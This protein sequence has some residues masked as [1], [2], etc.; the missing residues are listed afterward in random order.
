MAIVIPALTWTGLVG[1][2]HQLRSVPPVVPG[3]DLTNVFVDRRPVAWPITVAGERIEWHTTVQDLRSN[4]TL[5][6]YLHLADWNLVP[7]RFMREGLD[8]MLARYRPILMSPRAWDR[9]TAED[10][11]RVPQPMRTLAFRQMAAYW[12][13]Y[14]DLGETYGF[15]PGLIADTLGAIIMTESWF[16]HRGLFVNAE[17]NRDIGLGGASDYARERLR[18]MYEHGLVDAAFADDA[19]VNPWNAT[20]FVALWMSLML[21]EADGDLELAIR[22]YHRGIASAD[23]AAGLRYLAT[24]RSRLSRYIRNRNAPPA[25]DYVWKKG[26]TLERD[27]WP[28]V[29][30]RSRSESRPNGSSA[31]PTGRD[32]EPAASRRDKTR[33][34]AQPRTRHQSAIRSGERARRIASFLLPGSVKAPA[35]RDG[36]REVR[37]APVFAVGVGRHDISPSRRDVAHP[38]GSQQAL[39]GWHGQFTSECTVPTR[40]PAPRTA[41][42]VVGDMHT[43]TVLIVAHD[44]GYTRACGPA[45]AAARLCAVVVPTFERAL[46]ALRHFRPD[47]LVIEEGAARSRHDIPPI[48]PPPVNQLRVFRYPT[49][50]APSVLVA[51]VAGTSSRV[52][53]E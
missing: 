36:L 49:L 5:W 13:G 39:T 9:M 42:A 41:L 52:G 3:P 7:G 43:L 33:L 40:R 26:R 10:W 48:L 4:L 19:Y 15:P 50:P 1:V 29:A 17:G 18:Q 31:A 45:F 24:V 20:R 34:A 47:V 27:E 11:D 25:W 53:M 8:N 22:A 38:C 28:W 6:R 12:A 30:V 21:D 23:D 51:D 14:Y 35:R 16:D 44:R 37:H 46:A 2:R 32:A